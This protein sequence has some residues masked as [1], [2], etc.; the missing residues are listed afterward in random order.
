M[1]SNLLVFLLFCDKDPALKLPKPSPKTAQWIIYISIIAMASGM[2]TECHFSN[3]LT[4]ICLKAAGIFKYLF[5]FFF[6]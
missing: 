5:A 1:Q 2:T 4:G 6:S 3:I